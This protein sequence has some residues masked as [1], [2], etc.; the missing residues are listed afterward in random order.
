MAVGLQLLRAHTQMAYYTFMMIGLY[1]IY[2]MIES[3][4]KKTFSIQIVKSVSFVAMALLIGLIMSAWLYLPVQE[5]AQYSIRGGAVGL[6]YDYATSWSFSP[7][8][9]TTFLIPFFTG[10]GGETYWGPM[11]FTDFPLYMGI[12]PLFF[13]G[14]CLVLKRDRITLFFTIL[15]VLS[16]IVSFGKHLP[17][18]YG[19]LFKFLPF[20]N[21]FR[22]PTMILILLQFSVVVL[23]AWGLHAVI[24]L[25]KTAQQKVRKYIYAFTGLCGFIGLSLLIGKGTYLSWIAA[26]PKNLTPQLQETV[27]KNAVFDG[28]KMIILAGVSGFFVLHYLRNR[29]KSNAFL[30]AMIGLLIIDLWWVGFKIIDPKPQVN[31]ESHFTENEAV[32][33]LKKD[34]EPFRIYPVADNK[35]GNWYVSHKIQNILGYHAAKIRSYQSFLENTGLVSRNRFGLPPFMS[36]YL[37]VVIKDGQPSLQITAPGQIPPERFQ[38]DNAILDMLNVKYLISYYPIPDERF[39]QVVSSQP[40]VYENTAV[41]PRAYFVN[42]LKVVGGEEDFYN[43]LK[44]GAFDPSEQA[45]LEEEPEFDIAPSPENSVQ[46]TSYDIHEIKLEA[47]VVQPAL[48][49]L[50]EI[51]YP[52]G[53]R[54]FVNGNETKIYK[55]NAIL[56]SIFLEP[57]NHNIEF[58]FK[59]RSFTIGI[60]ITFGTLG[61]LLGVLIYCW[62][63]GGS[64]SKPELPR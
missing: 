11:P 14:I 19:P 44:S 25:D 15:A 54:A 60:W 43:L 57:G 18:L 26:S 7:Q 45:V 51:Y 55:T 61:V 38:M 10:F 59:S 1:L 29:I 22:V 52:A 4:L 21:K 28:I 16:L 49:V 62:R 31:E 32:R 53:W 12:V 36:K 63:F 2:W 35:P 46:V 3:V 58:V 9:I 6:D 17:I 34:N 48:M 56:R 42:E 39:K 40:S 8:E 27:Y 23:S 5:Y 30:A 47:Q 41:L 33:F 20:F 37:D 50:S 24:N 64:K 13:A